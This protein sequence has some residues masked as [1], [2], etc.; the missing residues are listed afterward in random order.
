YDYLHRDDLLDAAYAHLSLPLLI[1]VLVSYIVIFQSTRTTL[2]NLKVAFIFL[3]AWWFLVFASQ[4]YV[5]VINAG[6]GYQSQFMIEGE[7]VSKRT[8]RP[9][10]GNNG[11]DV[12]RI[13]ISR[14]NGEGELC[15][16][17]HR[18]EYKNLEVGDVYSKAWTEGSLGIIYR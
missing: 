12:Y 16:N 18:Y 6:M 15:F 14:S 13:C 5:L 1:I 4:G 10:R 2:D 11:K 3:L 9:S 8:Y 17:V 7:V